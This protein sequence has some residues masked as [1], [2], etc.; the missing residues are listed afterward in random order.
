MVR[1][2]N[3]NQALMLPGVVMTEWCGGNSAT[4]PTAA[5]DRAITSRVGLFPC[6]SLRAVGDILANRAR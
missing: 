1:A 2:F 4:P 3:A 5:A 6:V